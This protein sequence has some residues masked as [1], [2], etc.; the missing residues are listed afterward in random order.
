MSAMFNPMD[1]SGQTIL[2]TG[3]SSGIGRETAILLSRLGARLVVV[4]RNVEQLQRTIAR[5]EPG[6]HRAE[7]LDLAQQADRIPSW[8]KELTKEIGPLRGLVH[9]AGIHQARPLRF[10]SAENL[11]DVMRINFVAAVQLAK[12]F[13]Q[14]GVCASSS[15]IVFLSSVVGLVGQSGVS[16]YSASKGAL[17]ALSRSLA[18]ELVAE[19]IRVNCVAPGQVR[20]E[21]AEQQQQSLTAEQF[22][23]IEARH[24]LGLGQPSD[25]ASAIAFL[26]ADTG[27]WI[28]GTTLVVDGGYTA[29]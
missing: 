14:R 22:T 9:S 6:A 4:G 17:I 11:D 8:I 1:L 24:P 10:L 21:M 2:V 13:R 18:L 28:T 25:V 12:G 23:A 15:S 20:T 27:R 19:G 3:A 26:L 7:V 16:A 29:S 5:L